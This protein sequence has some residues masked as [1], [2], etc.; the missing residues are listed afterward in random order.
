MEGTSCTGTSQVSLSTTRGGG[1]EEVLAGGDKG[2]RAGR[3][4]E[5]RGEDDTATAGRPWIS[6]AVVAV[7]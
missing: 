3:S 2:G 7:T 6:K 4:S 5:V 1:M